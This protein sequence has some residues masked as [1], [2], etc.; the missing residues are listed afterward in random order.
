MSLAN[1]LKKAA[2]KTLLKLGGDITL[3]RVTNGIYNPA[4]GTISETIS[5]TTIKGALTNVSRSEVNDLV[6]AQDKLLIISAGD[7]TFV[8]TT[9]DKVIVAGVEFKIIQIKID[10]QDNTP[11]AYQLLLR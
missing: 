6:E 5:D 2:S 7:I 1:A 8:P 10:E 9:K 3:R 4:T 11:I